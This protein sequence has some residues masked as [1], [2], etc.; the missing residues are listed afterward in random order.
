MRNLSWILYDCLNITRYFMC[1]WRQFHACQND[2]YGKKKGK[3]K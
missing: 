1:V 2:S 3:N